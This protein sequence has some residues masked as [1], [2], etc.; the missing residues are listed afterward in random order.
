MKITKIIAILIASF[1][2][3]TITT[4]CNGNAEPTDINTAT[5]E[6]NNID[7]EGETPDNPDSPE[8][9]VIKI[10][11]TTFP[12]YDWI[13]EIIGNNDSL[14]ELTLLADSVVDLHSYEPS[15]SDIAKI[16]EC[17]MFIYVGGESDDWVENALN[18]AN[19]NEMVVINL[20]DELGDAVKMER[21]TDGMEHDGYDDD[22]DDD[23][24]DEHDDEHDD[25][26]EDEHV[27]LSLR[28][29]QLFCEVIS[30]AISLLDPENSVIYKNNAD[31]YIESLKALDE[32]YQIM[33]NAARVDT[34]LFADRF[35]FL[36]LVDD[37]GLD[38]YAAFS[39]CSAET[40][41]SFSTIATLA[42]KLDELGLKYIMV[43]ESSDKTIAEAII[44]NGS[45]KDQIILILDA[46][47][48]VTTVELQGG[49][50]YLSIME[51]NLE[52][53]REALE[54][55]SEPTLG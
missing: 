2:L 8:T 16:S 15:I 34:L 5:D 17:D 35:P 40:E 23:D 6:Q 7:T 42:G 19:N 36:Y 52:V 1:M 9:N 20:V 33:V 24:H 50:T 18:N 32:E 22:D 28:N 31:A 21:V 45:S 54:S 25:D 37:Y 55:E 38:F 46:M 3:L 41:A 48:S 14:F 47:Q 26:E 51:S 11:S 10:V 12:Q 49:V 43:T 44:E 53:L 39:G 4:A 29:A 13:R 27:W 30:E